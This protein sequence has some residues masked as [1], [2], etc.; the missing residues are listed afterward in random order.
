MEPV[1]QG[2]AGVEGVWVG[3][4]VKFWYEETARPPEGG[5]FLQLQCRAVALHQAICS[6]GN[7]FLE[8]KSQQ[9]GNEAFRNFRCDHHFGLFPFD[10]RDVFPQ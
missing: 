6:H 2:N 1:D 3:F 4:D 8:L 5:G 10:D 9:F 7:R